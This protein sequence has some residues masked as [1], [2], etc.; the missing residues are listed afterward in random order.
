MKNNLQIH[1]MK[2]M[3][4]NHSYL[5]DIPHF[6]D[7]VVINEVNKGWSKDV[8]YYIVY[9]DEN[10]YLLRLS[11]YDHYTTKKQEFEVMHMVYRHGFNMSRPIDFGVCNNGKMV[12]S[13]LSWVKGESLE[14]KIGSMSIAEQ[15]DLG[16]K[17]G[18]VLRKFHSIPA[19]D[20]QQ[21]WEERMKVKM[22]WHLEK[23]MACGIKVENDTYAIQYLN[24]NLHL[25]QGRNQVFQH[26]DFHIGNIIFGR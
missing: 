15:Y 24:D 1:T 21:D 13:L 9:T 12:Y 17:A 19:P 6:K 5:N 8:K 23:Y 10:E 14:E 4:E 18:K 16:G 11:A 3:K 20:D 7:W 26:G 25:L 22:T 2:M